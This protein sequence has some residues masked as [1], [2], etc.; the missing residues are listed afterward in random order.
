MSTTVPASGRRNSSYWPPRARALLNGRY[1]VEA[2]DLLALALP[3][4]RHRVLTNFYAESD[5]TTVD[6]VLQ[7]MI[8][9][10]PPPAEQ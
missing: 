8:E 7:A 3:V 4:L 6:D 9:A 2:A 5:K 10:K 1:H